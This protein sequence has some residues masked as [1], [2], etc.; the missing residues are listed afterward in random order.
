MYKIHGFC[1]DCVI[2]Y[3]A[4]LQKAGLFEEYERKMTQGNIK[5]F[6][7]DI[8]SWITESLE[9]KMS[10]VTEQGDVE[11]WGDLSNTYKDKIRDDLKKYL[12]LLREHVK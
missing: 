10:F 3:E 7:T 2:D 6:I 12:D 4:S 9:D 5:A 11:D 8:E 1:F